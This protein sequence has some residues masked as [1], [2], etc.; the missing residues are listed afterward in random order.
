MT[1][2]RIWHLTDSHLTEKPTAVSYGVNTFDTF[3]SIIGDV[4]HSVERPGMILHTGDLADDGAAGTYAHASEL[5]TSADIPVLLTPGNHDDLGVMEACFAGDYIRVG[6]SREI[7]N[8]RILTVNSQV[9]GRSHGR[10]S[11]ET[12]L[13]LEQQIVAA[14]GKFVV[15][16]LH[17]SPLEQCSHADCQL[18]NRQE[19]LAMLKKYAH[20]RCVLAG[21]THDALQDCSDDLLILAS[22]STFAQVTHP[23][24]LENADGGH[25][26]DC[27]RYGYRVLDLHADGRVSTSVHWFPYDA[28]AEAL[29]W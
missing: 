1:S 19:L 12:L 10:V 21:H 6:G 17:H 26:L 14:A 15:V 24:S 11:A 27:S 2:V 29:R 7:G 13:V 28:S 5:F 4:L 3:K 23:N 20:V 16:A 22:P 18:V 9:V 8:W 25:L